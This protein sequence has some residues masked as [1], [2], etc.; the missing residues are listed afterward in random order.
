[1]QNAKDI[2]KTKT[3]VSNGGVYQD[4]KYVQMACGIAYIGAL[5]A[6]DSWLVDIGKWSKKTTA[7]IE[8]YRLMVNKHPRRKLLNDYLNNVYENLHLWG[9]Y[10]GATSKIVIKEGLDNVDNIIKIIEKTASP[11]INK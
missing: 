10:S 6:M 5:L 7:S 8:A 9:Y 11:K 1:M 3:T 4:Q 2:L